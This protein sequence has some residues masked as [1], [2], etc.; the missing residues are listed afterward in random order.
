MLVADRVP[1]DR[2]RD[3]ERQKDRD[4]QS[5]RERNRK[6]MCGGVLERESVR[7]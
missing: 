1:G 2:E 7:V 4:R 5:D 6:S 3:K